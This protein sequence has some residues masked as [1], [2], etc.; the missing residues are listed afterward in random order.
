[1]VFEPLEEDEHGR[2]LQAGELGT[3]ALDELVLAHQLGDG[4]GTCHGDGDNSRRRKNRGHG[5]AFR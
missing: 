1:M 3:V 5:A 4:L 2:P